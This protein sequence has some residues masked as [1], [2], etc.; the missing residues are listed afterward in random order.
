[1]GLLRLNLVGWS[2]VIALGAVI[3]AVAAVWLPLP[4]AVAIGGVVAFCA[5]SVEWLFTWRDV[6]TTIDGFPDVEAA[7]IAAEVLRRHGIRAWPTENP[8]VDVHPEAG[9]GRIH[10][11]ARHRRRALRL[12]RPAAPR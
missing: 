3:S 2:A 6:Q 5:Y 4:I 12:I 7:G 1:M 11:A 10:V 8:D 9:A